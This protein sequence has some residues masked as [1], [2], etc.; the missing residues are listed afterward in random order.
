MPSAA[1]SHLAKFVYA[2]E[3][4]IH[5]SSVIFLVKSILHPSEKITPVIN[6]VFSLTNHILG[7]LSHDSLPSF[8]DHGTASGKGVTHAAYSSD[9]ALSLLPL[10]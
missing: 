7:S 6:H 3:S 1:M 8:I 4:L 10:S 5:H 2:L 9:A